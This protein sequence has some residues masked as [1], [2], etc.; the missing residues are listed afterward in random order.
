MK[1]LISLLLAVCLVL[2][3]V[4]TLA[5]ADGYS[6]DVQQQLIDLACATFPEYANF[7]RNPVSPNAL[8]RSNSNPT[9]VRSE[10]RKASDRV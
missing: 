5:S 4:P 2:S 8:S 1:K 10:A 3:A 6:N 7:I 9:L